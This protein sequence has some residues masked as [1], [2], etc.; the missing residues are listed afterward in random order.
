M[1]RKELGRLPL[2]RKEEFKVLLFG[3]PL[4]LFVCGFLAFLFLA[5]L[6]A[7]FIVGMLFYRRALAIDGFGNS[8]LNIFLIFGGIALPCIFIFEL[9]QVGLMSVIKKLTIESS[10]KVSQFFKGIAANFKS[11]WLYGIIVSLLSSLLIINVGVFTYAD[12][13]QTL[14]LVL[15]VIN[16]VLLLILLIYRPY[17]MFEIVTFNNSILRTLH[18]ARFLFIKKPGYAFLN[19]LT[20]SLPIIALILFPI[21]FLFIPISILCVGYLSFTNLISYLTNIAV[22]ENNVDQSEIPDIYHAGLEDSNS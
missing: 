14:S 20:Y 5:P 2:T 1:N 15:L 4:L 9:G 22:F 6:L 7:D 17:I 3:E 19:L 13:N 10:S 18:N 12:F 21:N 16:I 8:P 11:F